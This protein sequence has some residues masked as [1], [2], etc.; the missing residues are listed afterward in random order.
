MTNLET[1]RLFCAA[2]MLFFTIFLMSKP[3]LPA[4]L[5]HFSF[6][7]LFLA[8]FLTTGALLHG[9]WQGIVVAVWTVL[10]KVILVPLLI[11]VITAKTHASMQVKFF[12]RPAMTY[13]LIAVVLGISAFV[14]KMFPI[15][16]LGDDV[17]ILFIG[18]SLILLGLV[19]L[20]VRHDV[21]SQIIGFLILENGITTFS[22]IAI[23]DIPLWIELGIAFT[24]IAGALMMATIGRE[25]Q[26]VY[27][28][29]D[30][31]SLRELKE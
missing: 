13:F 22:S 21:F 10:F 15:H 8:G 4:V 14:I 11:L 6:A 2:G 29:G 20:V 1:L 26:L 19:F 12:A 31:D 25:I 9:N 16:L 18:L 7:S 17:T 3:R 5:R 24:T 30:T 23:S 27:S 28:T